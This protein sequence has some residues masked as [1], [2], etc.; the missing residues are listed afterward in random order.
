[1]GSYCVHCWPTKTKS[2]LLN[3]LDYYHDK[4]LKPF[5]PQKRHS[6]FWGKFLEVLAK[7]KLVEFVD[8]PDQSKLF[9]RSLI[10]FEEAKKRGFTIQ[11]VKAFGKYDNSFKVLTKGKFVFYEGTPLNVIG[12]NSKIDL[13][14]KIEVKKILQKRGLPVA[15]GGLFTTYEKAAAFASSVG[16]PLIVKPNTGSLSHHVSGRIDDLKAL[17]LAIKIVQQYRPDF[18][19][20]RFIPGKLYRATVIGKKHVLVSHKESANIVGDGKSTIKQLIGIKNKKR[21]EMGQLDATIHKIPVDDALKSRLRSL[22][23][24]LNTILPKAR[25]VY[26]QEKII[27]SAGCDVV[28]RT[29]ETHPV[30]KKLF[31]KTAEILEADLVGIDF[32][33]QNISKPFHMQACAIIETNSLPYIDMHQ[34]PSSGKAESVAPLVWDAFLELV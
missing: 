26:L 32:I 7:L 27:L 25:K 12:K 16:F 5:L 30:N 11:A 19:V 17:E 6:N 4:L 18:I 8:Q 10:F 34:N 21:G 24:T 15:D 3:H 14:N 1:M 9:N 33:A 20:E 2:H 23:F 13:D 31:L 22:G 29:T 28:S